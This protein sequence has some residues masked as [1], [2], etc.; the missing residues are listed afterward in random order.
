[1]QRSQFSFS[2]T[3]YDLVTFAFLAFEKIK[4]LPIWFRVFSHFDEKLNF[5]FGRALEKVTL[6]RGGKT[7]LCLQWLICTE[8]VNSNKTSIY[9]IE[10]NFCMEF[11][12][13]ELI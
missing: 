12:L 6:V 1:M 7:N 10:I 5:F 4:N 8:N 11:A 3:V 2:E 9:G 13:Y